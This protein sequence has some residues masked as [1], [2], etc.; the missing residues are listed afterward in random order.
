MNNN[1]L[2][3]GPAQTK[4]ARPSARRIS[5]R[6]YSLVNLFSTIAA[7]RER[8]HFRWELKRLAKDTPYLIDDIGLT[9]EQV[10]EEIAKLPFWQR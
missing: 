1:T 2:C 9:K 7:W 5:H 10:E 3:V 6:R 4:R 8:T